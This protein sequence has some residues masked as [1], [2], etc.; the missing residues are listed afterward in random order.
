MARDSVKKGSNNFEFVVDIPAGTYD[1]IVY[2]GWLQEA[3]ASKTVTYLI[4]ESEYTKTF[5]IFDSVEANNIKAA[6]GEP[7]K[8]TFTS[9]DIAGLVIQKVVQEPEDVHVAVIPD[10]V[11][12]KDYYTE[13]FEDASVLDSEGLPVGWKTAGVIDES[14]A[15]GERS[16]KT[17]GARSYYYVDASG[18]SP[19]YAGQVLTE[20]S[21]T[22][23]IEYDFKF[24]EVTDAT[25]GIGLGFLS[26]SVNSGAAS[27]RGTIM[28]SGDVKFYNGSNNI[29]IANIKDAGWVHFVYEL[30]PV[31]DFCRLEADRSSKQ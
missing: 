28:P 26:G 16:I 13:S 23:W 25:Y 8:L 11:E 12:R 27:I 10:G 5:N 2:G 18:N 7:L 6:E 30:W 21:K 3:D 24:E 14:I 9:G 19:R 15:A 22:G 4:G 20:L 31:T 17:D 1:V 29:T